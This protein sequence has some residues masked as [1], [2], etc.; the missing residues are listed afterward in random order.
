MMKFKIFKIFIVIMFLVSNMPVFAYEIVDKDNEF[1]IYSDIKEIYNLRDM[2]YDLAGKKN[3][4]EEIV[5]E[6]VVTSDSYWWPIGSK[7]TTN[8][9]GKEFAT[10]DP[11]TVVITSKFGATGDV[12]SHANGHGGLDIGGGRKGETNIIA[13][14]DGIVVY[15]VDNSKMTCPDGGLGNSCGG[16]YG[17]Y[18]ILQHSDGN[19]TLYGHMYA[20]SIT[21]KAGD[22]VK[23]GQVIGKMGTSG[24]SSGPHLH[25]EVR[26]GANDPSKKVDPLEYISADNPRPKSYAITPSG[27]ITYDD[28][29]AYIDQM[30]GTACES[31]QTETE[32]QACGGGDGVITLGHGVTWEA[33][34]DAFNRHGIYEMSVGSYVS[35]KI[36][37]EIELEEINK[38]IDYV[39]QSLAEAGIDDLKDYQIYALASQAYNGGVTIVKDNP[40]GYDFI[41]AYLRHNG[42]YSFD[43][44]YKHQSSIW[45]DAMCR[46]YAPGTIWTGLARRRVS[47]WRLFTT[48]EID[49]YEPF[50]R[51]KYAW[52]E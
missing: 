49:F 50:D 18:V 12:S 22:T 16:G 46:P 6:D 11:E 8:V 32:Y 30:E 1:S 7:E 34:E 43:D 45:Y 33:N 37:D 39:K 20:N 23:Q 27:V 47:E 31:N 3:D 40:N 5:Y 38:H 48:G 15:P 29:V 35:K 52:P 24:D 9:G 44:V 13:A 2:Y 42:E 36:V 41:S 10:G 26:V 19:F 4:D 14:K 25:F 51:D 17:N 21:V 28:L